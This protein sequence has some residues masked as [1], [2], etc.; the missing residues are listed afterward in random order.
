MPEQEMRSEDLCG[1]CASCRAAVKSQYFWL[2]VYKLSTANR[3]CLQ[4]K[5]SATPAKFILLPL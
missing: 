5:Y 1:N 4:V 3:R 2:R